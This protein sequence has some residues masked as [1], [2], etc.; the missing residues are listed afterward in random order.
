MG[1]RKE[2][3]FKRTS[4][5]KQPQRVFNVGHDFFLYFNV[6]KPIIFHSGRKVLIIL[7]FL[8]FS[9][10]VQWHNRHDVGAGTGNITAMYYGTHET[11]HKQ[12]SHCQTSR[13]KSRIHLSKGTLC[14]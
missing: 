2:L 10:L 11:G 12:Q 5:T 14:M 8:A 7:G 6:P 1:I 13:L 4:Y 9:I 3:R